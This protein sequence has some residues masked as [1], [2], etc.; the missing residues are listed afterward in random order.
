MAGRSE[1]FRALLDAE[2]EGIIRLENGVS[3]SA[4]KIQE[5]ALAATIESALLL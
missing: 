4:R 2:D 1:P 3:F 5:G